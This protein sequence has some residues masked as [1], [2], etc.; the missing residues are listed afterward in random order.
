MSTQLWRQVQ[1]ESKDCLGGHGGNDGK[2]KAAPE[3]SYTVRPEWEA[4][5]RMA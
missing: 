3:R 2:V 4:C 5:R 1:S